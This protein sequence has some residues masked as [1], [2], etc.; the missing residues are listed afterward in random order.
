MCYFNAE[1]LFNGI[2]SFIDENL[3][4]QIVS[5]DF[6]KHN[7]DELLFDKNLHSG[8]HTECIERWQNGLQHLKNEAVFEKFKKSVREKIDFTP[9]FSTDKIGLSCIRYLAHSF[10]KNEILPFEW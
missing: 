10:Y 4:L 2:L 8:Y 5:I 1:K 7:V 6:E 3:S 9:E